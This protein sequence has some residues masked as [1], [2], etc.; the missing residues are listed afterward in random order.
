MKEG[1]MVNLQSKWLAGEKSEKKVK[2]MEVV[3]RKK[4]GGQIGKIEREKSRFRAFKEE[5]ERSYK[6]P[7]NSPPSLQLIHKNRSLFSF[8]F[9]SGRWSPFLSLT[10][11]L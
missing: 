6:N 9:F 10:F 5:A 11:S 8:F 3:I 2:N 4:E 7:C 1:I